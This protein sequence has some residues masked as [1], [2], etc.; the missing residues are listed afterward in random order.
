MMPVTGLSSVV[1]A[2]AEPRSLARRADLAEPGWMFW[3]RR[4]LNLHRVIGLLN[5]SRPY[6]DVRMLDA[7]LR[8]VLARRFKRAWW[9]GIAWGVVVDG[10]A[11]PF[12]PDA[13]RVLVDTYENR[14]G[15]MQWVVLV[16]GGG[17][18]ATGVHTWVEGYL[19]P[20]YRAV[21]QQLERSGYRVASIRKEKD[22]P[23]RTGGVHRI[24]RSVSGACSR[25]SIRIGGHC[26]T[27]GAVSS[28]PP[29]G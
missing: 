16:D 22:G 23:M 5:R 28:A 14:R 3:E 9:R 2:A 25:R 18:E 6:T 11:N 15:T 20:V 26:R 7:E 1:A 12:T 19:S 24:P 8:G 17:R 21:L 27:I 10:G 4:N 29:A 13:L